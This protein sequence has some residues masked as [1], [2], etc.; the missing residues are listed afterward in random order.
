MCIR[1]R[2]RSVRRTG[3]ERRSGPIWVCT[4]EG[5]FERGWGASGLCAV[6]RRGG[7]SRLSRTSRTSVGPL[8]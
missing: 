6:G 1:D 5:R 2:A 4:L 3:S 7:Q 8:R